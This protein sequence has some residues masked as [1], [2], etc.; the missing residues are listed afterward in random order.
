MT[1]VKVCLWNIQ[2]FGQPT[3][4]YDGL[5]FALGNDLRNKF[6]A[7][8]VKHYAIDVLLI[9]E[10]QLDSQ[11][12]LADLQRKLNAV[13]DDK[14]DWAY[15]W[16]GSA[17]AE[18]DVDVVTRSADLTMRTGQ[19][20]EGYAVLWRREQQ[21]RF[22]LVDG[23]KPIAYLTGPI[24]ANLTSPLNIS[25]TGKPTGNL[26]AGGAG[27][28]AHAQ[29]FGASGGFTQARAYP[30][31][32]NTGTQLY[33][34]LDAWPKLNY[35]P[36]AKKDPTKLR[37]SRAR[38]PVYV[39]IKL[40]DDDTRLCPVSVYHAPSNS[41]RSSWGAFIAGLARELYAVNTAE[42]ATP[43]PDDVQ[44]ARYA[45]FGGDFNNAVASNAWPGDYNYF[46]AKRQRTIDGGAKCAVTPAANDAAAARRTTVQIVQGRNHEPIDSANAN[47]YLR[48]EI[49]LVFY[50]FNIAAQR[51][52]LMS[53][54]TNTE[55]YNVAIKGAEKLMRDT[56]AS[57]DDQPTRRQ[58]TDTGPQYRNAPDDAW[59]PMISGGWG[60]T[61]ID[62]E[63][64]CKQFKAGKI[65]DARRAAEYIHLFVSDH[66]PLL[67][68]IT[69]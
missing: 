65:T 45:V 48:H 24:I 32:Y 13:H 8:F 29:T 35:P 27:R 37:W 55:T 17:I 50:G 68:T 11:A 9:Q 6:I 47:D 53:I 60:G 39:V 21:D 63:E 43:D 46:V 64:S 51:I 28:G 10:A 3:P 36:T 31:R 2:N 38:R 44:V 52:N 57:V 54:V 4:R 58:M 16:C 1:D 41:E 56:E 22:T 5:R 67:A 66:M 30:T 49:D 15:S 33:D 12:A 62:W 18:N 42:G 69:Y 19:R 26:P 14:K 20:S 25:Q 61:F 40:G 7:R 23:L 59:K 34:D